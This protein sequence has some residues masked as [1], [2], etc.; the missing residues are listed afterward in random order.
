MTVRAY[1][2]ARYLCE[3]SDWRLSNLQL[4][5]ILY[6]ADMNFVGQTSE[7]LV[8]ENFQAWDYGPVLSS[9]YH[10]CKAFGKKS[11]PN[12][13]WG[14]NDIS[15]TPEASMLDL[16]LNNLEARK[17]HELV[18]TTH[19]PV[20]AWIRRYV[21]GARQIEISTQDMVDEYTRRRRARQNA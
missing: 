5:K 21:P 4:Q 6:M 7:R 8:A 17:P 9:L 20:G 2:A 16:A 15:G 1:D 12:I 19:S 13:F 18:S 10:H 3:K 14:A 11:L